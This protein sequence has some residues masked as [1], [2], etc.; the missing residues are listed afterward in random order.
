MV[1]YNFK[2]RLSREQFGWHS[3]GYL[4]HFDAPDNRTQF[5]TFRLADS[6]PQEL[7]DRWRKEART[8]AQF[9]RKVEAYLDAGH[10]S[11]VLRRSDIATMVCN[12]LKFHHGKKYDLHSWVVMPNHGHVALTPL[13]RFH[14]DEIEHSIKSFTANEANELLGRK[15]QFWAPECFDRYIRN[16]RHF[17]A[18]VK[19]IENNPVKAGLCR[20]PS[21]WKFGSAGDGG[22]G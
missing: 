21:D 1:D 12:S 2:P 13:G 15:G 5:L 18:V 9:R 7:L 16:Y 17:R 4:P 3:R 20:L 22:E 10:G 8:D 6:M 11:C 14:L 19:Y